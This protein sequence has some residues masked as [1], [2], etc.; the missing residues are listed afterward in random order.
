MGSF[1][2]GR[3]ALMLLAA[4]LRHVAGTKWG[5]HKY[6]NMSGLREEGARAAR[7]GEGFNRSQLHGFVSI[8]TGSVRVTSVL[9]APWATVPQDYRKPRF[10]PVM[11]SCH[12]RSYTL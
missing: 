2:D 3:S 5:T 4:S 9:R 7:G 10:L 12:H 8:R 6:M 11:A 1:P